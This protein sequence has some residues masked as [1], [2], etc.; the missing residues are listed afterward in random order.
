MGGAMRE[1]GT[2]RAARSLFIH[3]CGHSPM[4]TSM[5]SFVRQLFTAIQDSLNPDH[6]PDASAAP[7]CGGVTF[8]ENIK[9]FAVP[10]GF[11]DGL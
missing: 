6:V 1:R 5:I 2:R 9:I 11:R 4:A 3:V 7:G 10:P 8:S